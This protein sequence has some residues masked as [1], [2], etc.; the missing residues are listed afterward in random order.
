MN[1]TTIL[2]Y[3]R[4]LALAERG[5]SGERENAKAVLERME[6]EFP[7]IGEAARKFR[8]AAETQAKAR[9]ATMPSWAGDLFRFLSEAT[10]AVADTGR[11]QRLLD[12]VEL[13]VKSRKRG[14]V[15]EQRVSD[16]L[17][18]AL[19]ELNPLQQETFR[20]GL[21]RLID[22]Q[23]DALFGLETGED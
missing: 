21:H 22:E 7:G 4:V 1:K 8:A 11:A 12:E 14:V 16:G 6:A 15:L 5:V 17:V 23:I 3:L 13:D 9:G 18:E 10:R 19:R 20:Y 2:R